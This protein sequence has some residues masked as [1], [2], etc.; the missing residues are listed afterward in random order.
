[1]SNWSVY[2]VRC[3]DGT[4]YTGIATD[5]DRRLEEH[6]AG[7]G[8]RYLR[9]RGPLRLALRREI[10]DRAL[11]LRGEARGKKRPRARTEELIA[12]RRLLDQL[13]TRIAGEP[14]RGSS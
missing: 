3:G 1:M 6:R 7:R 4:L 8:A 10:G 5:V 9:G 11:A 14:G 13:A 12:R 2:L